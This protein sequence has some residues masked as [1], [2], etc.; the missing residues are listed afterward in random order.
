MLAGFRKGDVLTAAKTAISDGKIFVRTRKR[1]RLVGLPIHPTLANVLANAPKHQATTI[2]ANSYGEPWTESGFNS[3]FCKFIRKMEVAGK[4]EPGLTMHGLRHTLG[5]R[6]KEAGAEDGDI[7]DILGQ[8]TTAMARHYSDQADTSEKSRGLI[9]AADIFGA[10]RKR[11][12]KRATNSAAAARNAF[13][14]TP[15]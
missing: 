12:D 11:P 10:G 9:E 1:N 15:K 7:A 13:K 3:T 8:K 5:T 2:A 14:P 4:V 6:L